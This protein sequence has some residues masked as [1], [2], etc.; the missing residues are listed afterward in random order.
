MIV[1][2]EEE[3]GLC[4]GRMFIQ[5]SFPREN[6]TSQLL[7]IMANGNKRFLIIQLAVV[8]STSEDGC[9][10]HAYLKQRISQI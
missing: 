2:C 6:L 1:E 5:V 7:G 10:K 8:S 9:S 3:Y 4:R